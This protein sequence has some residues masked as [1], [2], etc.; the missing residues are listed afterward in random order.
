MLDEVLQ[1][2]G[3]RPPSA[4]GTYRGAD[5]RATTAR[6]R[7]VALGLRR[8][9][10]VGE[11]ERRRAR[12]AAGARCRA[13][14]G[15]SRPRRPGRSPRAR[16]RGAG[17]R[18]PRRRARPRA[19]GSRAHRSRAA[20]AR[21]APRPR[22]AAAASAAVLAREHEAR[23]PLALH[24]GAARPVSS[25]TGFSPGVKSTQPAVTQRR[26]SCVSHASEC[27]RSA[28]KVGVRS[29]P[30]RCEA[31]VGQAREQLHR[32][33]EAVAAVDARDRG[34]RLAHDQARLLVARR[35]AVRSARHTSQRPQPASVS[36]SS[37]K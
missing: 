3:A 21:A 35:V 27:S 28:P 23:G 2:D 7:A 6:I 37:P 15:R 25:T 19:G 13:A 9:D 18:A 16:A 4:C 31:R 10:A 17:P 8:A 30:A 32:R 12:A 11:L 1:E 33:G 5:A 24:H 26:S 29:S 20:G 14:C 36:S 22:G 34:E